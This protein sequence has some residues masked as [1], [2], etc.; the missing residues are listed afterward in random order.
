MDS[1]INWIF[2]ILGA[3]LVLLTVYGALKSDRR[4]FLSGLFYFSFL[5]LIGESIAYCTDKA[6]VHVIVI[7]VF[8][9]QLALAFPNNMSY[10]TDNVAATKLSAKIAVAFL[11]IN[12]GGI[13]YIFHLN[14]GVP[15]QF[16]YYHVVLALA[17]L[18]LLIRRTGGASW[19]K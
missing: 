8:L 19:N 1:T 17:I 13:V 12:I 10:G 9:V 3:A 18:Y 6:S 5:P 15:V 7:F 4:L 14:S 2:T 16:G 11:L